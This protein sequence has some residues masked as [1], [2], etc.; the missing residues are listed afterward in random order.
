MIKLF[1]ILLLLLLI[2]GSIFLI[3]SKDYFIP[4]F[5]HIIFSLSSYT[6]N[7]LK[8]VY[9]SGRRNETKNNII[10]ALNFDVGEPLFSLNLD[11]IRKNI[12]NLSWVEKSNIYL[13]PLG[14]LEIEIIEYIPFGRYADET[15]EYFLINN[16]GIKFKK[17]GINEF[18]SIFKLHGLGALLYVNELSFIINKL[19]TF[20]LEVLIA[21]RID[22]RRWNIYLKNRFFIKLPHLNATNSLEALYKLDNNIDYDNL[23]FIDLRIKDRVSIK[24]KQV[25]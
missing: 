24:Y 25:D 8:E 7:I 20:N 11:Q 9:V 3:Y 12:N 10:Q 23:I 6:D 22:S 19:K 5:N 1:K 17:I 4:K 16:K 18:Q 21:E 2:I 13:L 15:G 14:K